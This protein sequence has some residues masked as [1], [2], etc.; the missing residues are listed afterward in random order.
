MDAEEVR[1]REIQIERDLRQPARPGAAERVRRVPE[2]TAGG[3]QEEVPV[4]PAARILHDLCENLDELSTLVQN[5]V[6][7]LAE[8]SAVAKHAKPKA[9]F[10]ELE[11]DN[12][13]YCQLVAGTGSIVRFLVI[14]AGRRPALEE[15]WTKCD[16]DGASSVQVLHHSDDEAGE[17]E[18]SLP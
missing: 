14:R 3:A 5:R 7:N 6:V 4:T 18:Q 8:E 13:P 10:L 17:K 15:L 2:E 1:R 16:R 9:G 11:Q 12:P